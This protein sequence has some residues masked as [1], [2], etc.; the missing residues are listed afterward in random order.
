[1]LAALMSL[2]PTSAA[3]QTRLSP[4]FR[5]FLFGKQVSWASSGTFHIQRWLWNAE[6]KFM[7]VG[8]RKT[9]SSKSSRRWFFSVEMNNK[10][11]KT[12]VCRARRAK[13][14]IK[15]SFLAGNISRG[16]R[17]SWKE[18]QFT[19]KPWISKSRGEWTME[20]DSTSG[21]AI[22]RAQ[23]GKETYFRMDWHL[24]MRNQKTKTNEMSVRDWTQLHTSS[25]RMTTQRSR[26]IE[27]N[28]R[29]FPSVPTIST[30]EHK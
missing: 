6:L 5:L 10:G 1:M 18:F 14:F 28:R 9:F 15:I 21:D 2:L 30:R 4:D 3:S 26:M 7:H 12:K 13:Q 20:S 24:E 17:R 29:T 11:H 27:F 19:W 16:D 22:D 23:N 8:V 25:H